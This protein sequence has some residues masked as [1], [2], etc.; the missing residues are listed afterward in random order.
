MIFLFLNEHQLIDVSELV[1]NLLKVIKI[2]VENDVKKLM[3]D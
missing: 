1:E 2:Y 3:K